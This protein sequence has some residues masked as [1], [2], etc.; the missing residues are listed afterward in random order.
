LYGYQQSNRLPMPHFS[1]LHFDA[2]IPV[3]VTS[4]SGQNGIPKL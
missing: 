2:G 4:Q 1:A 3:P